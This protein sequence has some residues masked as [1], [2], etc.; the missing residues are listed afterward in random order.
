MPSDPRVLDMTAE[1]V[2]DLFL[3]IE[4]LHPGNEA[5]T[6]R[7]DEYEQAVAQQ[8]E[9]TRNVLWE[10]TVVIPAPAPAGEWEEIDLDRPLRP[11]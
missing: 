6:L 11:G 3:Q 10:E 9:E 7:D 2:T 5:E 4:H 1:Q 8:A